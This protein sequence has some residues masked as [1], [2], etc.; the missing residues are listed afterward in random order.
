MLQQPAETVIADN[1]EPNTNNNDANTTAIP[2]NEM[3]ADEDLPPVPSDDSEVE[4]GPNVAVNTL[5]ANDDQPAAAVNTLPADSGNTNFQQRRR[6]M[7]QGEMAWLRNFQRQRRPLDEPKNDSEQKRQRIYN[8]V[9][10]F[11]TVPMVST[12][13]LQVTCCLMVG[14]MMKSPTPLSLAKPKTFGQLKK[15]FWSEIM[16]LHVTHHG[17]QLPMPS[18][19]SPL[20]WETCKP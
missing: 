12:T 11:S 4:D 2:Q 6:N 10:V 19:M 14:P 17:D 7:D 13:S 1:D 3:P 9:E 15:V 5:P 20:S 8:S 18:K 16:S